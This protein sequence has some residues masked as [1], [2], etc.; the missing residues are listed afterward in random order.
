MEFYILAVFYL[1]I[2]IISQ[3]DIIIM[4]IMCQAIDMLACAQVNR[5]EYIANKKNILYN[6]CNLSVQTLLNIPVIGKI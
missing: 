4:V 6:K 1:F 3:F 5:H 2:I